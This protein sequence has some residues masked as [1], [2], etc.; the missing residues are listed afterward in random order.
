MGAIFRDPRVLCATPWED[1]VIV[2]QMLWEDDVS[3]VHPEHLDS[4]QAAANV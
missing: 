1:S 2:N 3:A 4:N